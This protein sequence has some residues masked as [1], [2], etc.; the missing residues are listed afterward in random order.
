L[1]A[2][3]AAGEKWS[4]AARKVTLTPARYPGLDALLAATIAP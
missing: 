2:R 1:L 3:L 4:G